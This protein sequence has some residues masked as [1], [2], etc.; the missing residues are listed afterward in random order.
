MGGRPVTTASDAPAWRLRAFDRLLRRFADQGPG[1]WRLFALSLALSLVPSVLGYTGLRATLVGVVCT[2]AVF[3]VA[4]T[5]PP[6][7]RRLAVWFFVAGFAVRAAALMALTSWLA[8]NGGPYLS[9]DGQTYWRRATAIALGE[10]DLKAGAVATIGSYD[11]AAYYYYAALAKM[12]GNDLFALQLVN[13]GLSSLVAP[14]MFSW[15]Q[16]V[17]PGLAVAL[18][19][20]LALHPSLVSMS[21]SNLLKDPSVVFASVVV[22][23]GT[24]RLLDGGSVRGR[25][26]YL[27]L[28]ALAGWY[29]RVG[30]FYTQLYLAAG[31]GIA[32]PFVALAADLRSRD[33]TAGREDGAADSPS[34]GRRPWRH[35][36][37]SGLLLVAV[38]GTVEVA[39]ITAGWPPAPVQVVRQVRFSLRSPGMRDY[40]PGLLEARR[41]NA[42][43]QTLVVN[44]IRRLFGPFVWVVP[45]RWDARV[46]I[47]G[48]YLLYP[49]MIIWYV[50]L[51]FMFAGL[52]WVSVQACRAME[53]RVPVVA[54]LVFSLVYFAQFMLINLSYRQRDDALPF[55]LVFAGLG[56]EA[57][58][59]WRPWRVVYV[60]YWA[61]IVL[62]ATVHLTVRWRMGL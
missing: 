48:D 9:P 8:R 12:F 53:G 7:D 45:N 29:L 50:C 57:V 34:P 37:S 42:P 11:V 62:M 30:R 2:L 6:E 46:L 13:V 35:A 4:R 20:L 24:T 3:V 27:V 40:A 56:F 14:L 38:F 31:F 1:G 18:G 59:R 32:V 58:R 61:G 25:V 17:V 33:R 5:V 47:A 49:G 23:W 54:L 22:V 10:F 21:A 26:M 44:W 51:P 60:A 43:V 28:A 15:G 55:L 39:A 19:V 52:A 16:R 41:S 36:V